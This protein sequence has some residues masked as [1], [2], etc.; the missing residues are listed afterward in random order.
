MV[1]ILASP[2]LSKIR[3][4]Y[5]NIPMP[6]SGQKL[7]CNI[8]GHWTANVNKAT[9]GIVVNLV[10]V[11]WSCPPKDQ[12]LKFLFVGDG[13]HWSRGLPVRVKDSGI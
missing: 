9:D 6:R 7:T 13:Q 11:I 2:C 3:M 5:H 10:M 4:A 1:R 8:A 12:P